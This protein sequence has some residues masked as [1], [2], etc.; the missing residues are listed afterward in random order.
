MRPMCRIERHRKCP[1]TLVQSPQAAHE[2]DAYQAQFQ[3]S[4]FSCSMESSVAGTHE[5]LKTEGGSYEHFRERDCW[6]SAIRFSQDGRIYM[7]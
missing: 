6:S 4:G 7:W 2:C 3:A 1:R 5:A